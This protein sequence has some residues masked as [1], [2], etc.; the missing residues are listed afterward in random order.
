LFAKQ[1]DSGV[2]TLAKKNQIYYFPNII[3]SFAR[4][5]IMAQN[6]EF[7]FQTMFAN[8]PICAPFTKCHAVKK[9]LN[10][11]AGNVGEIDSRW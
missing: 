10:L 11:C 4:H 2:Q 5:K 8:R 9:P 1:K 6:S 3:S 7:F